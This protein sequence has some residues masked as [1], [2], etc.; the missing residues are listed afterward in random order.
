MSVPMNDKPDGKR[1][2]WGLIIMVLLCM[3]VAVSWHSL[4][5]TRPTAVSL[6]PEE[7]EIV[8]IAKHELGNQQDWTFDKPTRNSDGSWEVS[9]HRLQPETPGG[10]CTVIIDSKRKVT[11]IIGGA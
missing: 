9:A 8:D 5:P 2:W 10:Y 11:R 4:L 7:A 3:A 1:D 6:S